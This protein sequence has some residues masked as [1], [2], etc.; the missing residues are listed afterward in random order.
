MNHF[1]PK[2]RGKYFF[3][4]LLNVVISKALTFMHLSGVQ[5]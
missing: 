3:F 1:V 4:P 5:E 2:T